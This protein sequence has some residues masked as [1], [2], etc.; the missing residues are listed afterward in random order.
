MSGACTFPSSPGA[1]PGP[2]ACRPNAID[3]RHGVAIAAPL[4]ARTE[5]MTAVELETYFVGDPDSEPKRSIAGLSSLSFHRGL[6]K[7][8]LM[9]RDSTGA[10][11]L[12]RPRAVWDLRGSR[13]RREV[14]L[15]EP[16]APDAVSASLEI[17]YVTVHEKTG[18]TVYVRVPGETQVTLAGCHGRV[19]TSRVDRS[20]DSTADRPSPIAGLNGP[21]VRIMIVPEDSEAERSLVSCGV[22]ESNDRGMTMSIDRAG[23]PVIEVP[24]PTGDSPHVMLHVPLV[25][26]LGPWKL[27]IP[28]PRP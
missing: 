3:T 25:R 19:T 15:F 2:L 11:H 5:A 7:D 1:R 9:I 23:P 16:M 27:E 28:L 26:L 21:C 18:E 20:S 8:L 14:A 6:A 22:L 4:V 12:E 24:D 17:P 13:R 10:H